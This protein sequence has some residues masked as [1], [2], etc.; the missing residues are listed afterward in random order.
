[1]LNRLTRA[2]K[3]AVRR[4]VH[5]CGRTIKHML[6]PVRTGAALVCAVSIDAVRPRSALVAENALLRQQILVLRRAAP[7]RPRLHAEDRLIL[8]FLARLNTAW[9]DALHVVKPDTLLRWPR[10]LFTLLWHHKSRRRGA[11]GRVARGAHRPDPGHGHCQR[12]VGR[13]TDPRRTAQARHPREQAD[14]PTVHAVR[15]SSR[16]ARP[17][18]GDLPPE[19]HA[20]IW[21][22]DVLQLY[23]AWFRPI[24]A[25][26]IVAHGT[27]E[28]VHV[29]VTRSPTDAWVAQQLREATPY[30][31]APRFLIRDNDGKFGRD[32]AAAATSADIDVVPIPPRS[33]NL[34]AICE[35][36]LGG[37]R[38]E[39]LGSCPAPWGGPPTPRA[40]RMGGTL[41]R[42]A[43]APGDRA[44]DPEPAAAA[45]PRRACRRIVA[46]PVLGGLH[47]DYRR[48]A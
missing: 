44:A 2:V 42:G 30:D 14:G 35:R 32:F 39:C 5:E 24:Y 38:R 21:A 27:R 3:T 47:H 6:R 19:P 41:Q 23:D 22:G 48:A 36:F 28:V 10:D 45:W 29:N 4:R 12:A 26:F 37:L 46:F 11:R 31:S 7:S 34:N 8:V 18:L 13:R 17:D 20:D 16:A 1:M 25:F 33:P 15:P 43:T 40:R 9:R